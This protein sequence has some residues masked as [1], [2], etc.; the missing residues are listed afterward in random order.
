[1]VRGP[2]LFVFRLLWLNN[3]SL[4]CPVGKLIETLLR[5]RVGAQVSVF[6]ADSGVRPSTKNGFRTCSRISA[7]LITYSSA[8]SIVKSVATF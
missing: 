2:Q 7:V 8:M 1:V 5:Y 3:G 4:V 6:V